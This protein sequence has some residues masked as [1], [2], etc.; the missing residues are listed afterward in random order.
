M[1]RAGLDAMRVAQEAEALADEVG[2]DGITLATI[3]HRLGVKVPSLYKHVDG[4]DALRG[5][6]AA[7]ARRELAEVLEQAAPGG[8]LALAHAYREWATL[9]P[10]RY[11]TTLRAPDPHDEV[12][13]DIS[14]RL[15]QVIFSMLERYG[16]E[17]E[18]AVDATR[19]L[20]AAL[21]GFI[22]LEAAG[23]FGLPR[24]IDRSFSLMIDALAESF[25][26]WPADEKDAAVS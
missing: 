20:R 7:R 15:V 11:P 1:P 26:R 19:T 23:G 14:T 10:G 9:H 12:D 16:L 21:H 18:R 4:L 22:G 24:E 8:L 6:V 3:A 5:L 13:S 25:A 17:G 2:I